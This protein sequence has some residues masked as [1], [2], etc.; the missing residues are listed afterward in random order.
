MVG[1]GWEGADDPDC[2]SVKRRS[3]SLD[4]SSKLQVVMNTMSNNVRKARAKVEDMD[5]R[6]AAV[7]RLLSLSLSLSLS[8]SPSVSASASPSVTLL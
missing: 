6:K 8:A 2:M 1:V 5:R 7:S 3:V 4:A